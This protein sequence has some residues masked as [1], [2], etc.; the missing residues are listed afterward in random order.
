MFLKRNEKCNLME[1]FVCRWFFKGLSRYK[2]EELL[3]QTH[4]CTGAFLVRESESNPGWLFLLNPLFLFCLSNH[5]PCPLFHLTVPNSHD[6][7]NDQHNEGEEL[8]MFWMNS[9][10][11]ISYLF[12]F[13]VF[14]PRSILVVCFKETRVVLGL[15]KALPHQPYRKRLVLHSPEAHLFLPAAP[16]WALYWWVHGDTTRVKADFTWSVGEIVAWHIQL[17]SLQ[18][19][20]MG[21]AV[22]WIS[23]ASS[24]VQTTPP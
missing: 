1:H 20:P 21:Y 17:F 11:P 18:S 2:A 23:P 19:S 8:W 22:P 9:V 24:W 14:C 12:F 13:F 16:C 10:E 3:M 4:N 5:T 6:H 7:E 15:G